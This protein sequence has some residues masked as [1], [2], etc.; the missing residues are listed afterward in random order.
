MTHNLGEK[1]KLLR[2]KYD[3]TQEQLAE[4]LGVSFQAISKWETNAAVPDISM[5]PILANFYKVTTDELLGV[6]ITMADEKIAQYEKEVYELLGGWQLAEAV[7]TARRACGE[8]PGSDNLRYLLAHT[9][10]QA[11]NVIRTKEENLTEAIEILEKILETSTDAS[12]R[13]A[14]QS[15]L[16]RLFQYSGDRDKALCYAGQL[17]ILTHTQEYQIIHMGLLK[18][19]DC[20]QYFR[21]IID[22]FYCCMDEGIRS[23]CGIWP[24]EKN[25]ALPPEEQ[26]AL[27]DSMLA[28]QSVIYGNDLLAENMNAM[29]YA[30][31]KAAANCRLG[32]KDAALYD[33]ETAVSHAE[34]FAAYDEE[35]SYGSPFQEGC[36]TMKRSHWS[37]SA[38]ADLHDELSG[39]EKYVALQGSP[40]FQEI[41][42]KV[43]QAATKEEKGF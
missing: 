15:T 1:L 33:L 8:F 24:Y 11:Q 27:L 43:R 2:K 10:E 3:L 40:K 38:F 12:L 25:E 7:E 37:Q 18:G 30:Y 23:L 17:P 31:T 6:D 41:L 36:T 28:L 29:V 14:C 32:N 26:I 21:Y 5:F 35:A 16:V 39:K 9:L 34:K 13:L 42:E 20:V 22:R 19:A 4:R